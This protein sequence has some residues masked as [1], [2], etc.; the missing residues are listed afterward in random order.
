MRCSQCPGKTRVVV[1]E[2]RKDGTH[3]WLRCLQ[4]D[5]LTRTIERY[6]YRKPGPRPGSPRIGPRA[7]GSRNGASVLT[8]SDI[9]RLRDL[10][11]LGYL[12]KEI[13]KEYGV[14]PTTVSNIVNRKTWSHVK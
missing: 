11:S 14:T 12:Q 7:I 8:E 3:R 13:A 5:A 10:A 2:Q 9:V 4:C 6:L 1:T